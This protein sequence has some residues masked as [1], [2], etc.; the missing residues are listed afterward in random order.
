MTAHF[1]NTG[2]YLIPPFYVLLRVIMVVRDNNRHSLMTIIWPDTPLLL[3]CITTMY[4]EHKRTTAIVTVLR[5]VIHHKKR[6]FSRALEKFELQ[7]KVV[8]LVDLFQ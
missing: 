8:E 4:L 6:V 1:D 5:A 2:T 7:Q 3:N